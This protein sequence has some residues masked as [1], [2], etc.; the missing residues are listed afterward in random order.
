MP[1]HAADKR[2]LTEE[3][4]RT[5]GAAASSSQAAPS[6]HPNKPAKSPHPKTTATKPCR[7]FKK[8][9]T[10]PSGADCPFR[11]VAPLPP[12]KNGRYFDSLGQLGEALRSLARTKFDNTTR[13]PG[14]V[15]LSNLKQELRNASGVSLDERVLEGGRAG[16]RVVDVLRA[17]AGMEGGAGVRAES[18]PT[19]AG[20]VSY[21]FW[22]VD[23]RGAGD[24]RADS[25]GFGEDGGRGGAE[26][27]SGPPCEQSTGRCT[28]GGS[29]SGG[30]S[31]H[32]PSESGARTR[33]HDEQVASLLDAIQPKPEYWASSLALLGRLKDYVTETLAEEEGEI[34]VRP[35]G[36]FQQ[37]TALVGSDIDVALICRGEDFAKNRDGK[38]RILKRVAKEFP[39]YC[40]GSSCWVKD[41]VW[42]AKV[43]LL[44]IEFDNVEADI[45]V[46]DEDSG[47]A[48]EKIRVMLEQN[49]QV[50]CG[51]TL[52]K[53]WVRRRLAMPEDETRSHAFFGMPGSFAWVILWLY[54]CVSNKV[55]EPMLMLGD[56]EESSVGGAG[57]GSVA[58][59]GAGSSVVVEPSEGGG[60]V[61]G[62]VDSD[63]DSKRPVGAKSSAFALFGGF[64][65]FIKGLGAGGSALQKQKLSLRGPRPAARGQAPAGAKVLWL[66]NPG[67]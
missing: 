46:G 8:S 11:H 1:G 35:F 61:E 26:K 65:S 43:P 14:R 4:P 54:F 57:G 20:G 64:L 52:F 10:C 63:N 17:V 7:F 47:V 56:D 9:G 33:D 32:H 38:I 18:V 40:S 31:I 49:F 42:T 67:R 2:L 30:T 41:T 16:G 34:E 39:T 37:C 66:E 25:R 36:S 3:G 19:E 13:P 51:L 12:R 6:Q 50:Q 45:S 60:V 44:R 53:Y 22:W 62:A 23:D 55:I 24:R 15:V 21:E 27:K 5:G 58:G 29:S 28:D 48:D 59:S